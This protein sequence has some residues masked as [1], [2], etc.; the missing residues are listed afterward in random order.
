MVSSTRG[1][2][3]ASRKCTLSQKK[4][5]NQEK[6]IKPK[7]QCVNKANFGHLNDMEIVVMES[8]SELNEPFSEPIE[9]MSAV[10]FTLSWS[11]LLDSVEIDSDSELMWSNA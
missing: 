5:D 10:K 1:S 3:A 4:H 2:L 7:I 9:D 8:P 6:T 11:L